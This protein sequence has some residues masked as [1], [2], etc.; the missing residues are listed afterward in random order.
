[1]KKFFASINNFISVHA[2]AIVLIIAFVSAIGADVWS[3]LNK[4]ITAY[5]DA[6]AH[7]VIARRVFDNLTPGLAQL[8]GVWLPLLHILMLP[9]VVNNFLFYTGLA[10]TL[11]NTTAYLLSNIYLFS[12]ISLFTKNK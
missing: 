9:F 5:G 11:V 8:G 4:Y 7:L 12:L 2:L 3:Y 1:M 10:G 6:Q